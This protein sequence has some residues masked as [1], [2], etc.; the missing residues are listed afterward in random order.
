MNETSEKHISRLQQINPN[1]PINEIVHTF[2]QISLEFDVST[3]IFSSPKYNPSILSKYIEVILPFAL[4]S[5]NR[6]SHIAYTF[7]D[8]FIPVLI[9]YS[10]IDFLKICSEIFKKEKNMSN[11]CPL[12]RYISAAL[13]FQSNEI[14]KKHTEMCL[15]ILTSCTDAERQNLYPVVWQLISKYATLEDTRAVLETLN[16]PELGLAAAHLV[17]AKQKE[18]VPLALK[19]G[20]TGFLIAFL[21]SI[22]GKEP[23]DAVEFINLLHLTTNV[24]LIAAFLSSRIILDDSSIEDTKNLCQKLTN[25]L[26]TA[27]GEKRAN[28]LTALSNAAQKGYIDISL[29]KDELNCLSKS[30]EIRD[31]SYKIII[32]NVFDDYKQS[33]ESIYK[34][35]G[36]TLKRFIE[37]FAPAVP[38]IISK[39]KDWAVQF[40]KKLL[41]VKMQNQV[42]LLRIAFQASKEVLIPEEVNELIKRNLNTKDPLAGKLIFKLIKRYKIRVNVTDLDWFANSRVAFEIIRAP[43]VPFIKELIEYGFITPNSIK[44]VLKAFRLRPRVACRSMFIELLGLA[45]MIVKPLRYQIDSDK[46]IPPIN[47]MD[48]IQINKLFFGT[49]SPFSLSIYG[50]LA[51]ELLRTLLA[52]FPFYKNPNE[53]IAIVIM[54]FCLLFVSS[55]TEISISLAIEVH[56]KV[57]TEATDRLMEQITQEQVPVKYAPFVFRALVESKG[58]EKAC[59]LPQEQ[60]TQA[61]RYDR[62]IASMF[63]KNIETPNETMKTFLSFVGI[64][65]HKEWVDKCQHEIDA[66]EWILADGDKE[67]IESLPKDEVTEPKH[68]FVLSQIEENEEAEHVSEKREFVLKPIEIKE[69]PKSHKFEEAN[70]PNLISFLWF[71]PKKLENEEEVVNFSY[72]CD[73]QRLLL[74]IICYAERFN[75]KLDEEKIANKLNAKN[76]MSII[77]SAL[78]FRSLKY[79]TNEIPQFIKDA[80]ER[81]LTDLNIQ[82]HQIIDKFIRSKPLTKF[83]I[84]SIAALNEEYK[85]MFPKEESG[86]IKLLKSDE[87]HTVQQTCMGLSAFFEATYRPNG[88]VLNRCIPTNYDWPISILS[89]TRESKPFNTMRLSRTMRDTIIKCVSNNTSLAS[90]LQWIDPTEVEVNAA[91]C[92]NAL[93]FLFPSVMFNNVVDFILDDDT[94]KFFS[95]MPPSFTRAFSRSLFVQC[96]P[97]IPQKFLEELKLA[98]T[99]VHGAVLPKGS[100]FIILPSALSLPKDIANAGYSSA[101]PELFKEATSGDCVSYELFSSF[102]DDRICKELK[103]TDASIAKSE[104]AQGLIENS[105]SS[106]IKTKDSVND[107]IKI[108]PIGEV[109]AIV[110]SRRLVNTKN[111]LSVCVAFSILERH[112]KDTEYEEVVKAYREPALSIINDESHRNAFNNITE[113]TVSS[114]L[115]E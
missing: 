90:V 3:L 58:F 60:I 74:G 4:S 93:K 52:L 61:I 73:D 24:P 111:F 6:V 78:F 13:S 70:L 87:K 107:I 27:Q 49:N 48:Q 103:I 63:A 66:S 40:V 17:S 81:C 69:A 104:A 33:F 86:I 79:S 95:V 9:T 45:K 11:M 51:L 65:K 89:F 15:Q 35:G 80:I 101:I 26:T 100:S 77:S 75:I 14:Q 68:A 106:I 83:L 57:K 32:E 91:N 20:D 30:A 34:Q 85:D 44:N 115:H 114:L 31:V 18:L 109:V 16:I 12:L 99:P 96:A 25:D 8:C 67:R 62:E 82:K 64:E 92:K 97:M 55:Y 38:K 37:L 76:E 102:S 43:E 72:T 112:I 22:K 36:Q 71:S 7:F 39:D 10:G 56:R 19:K 113:E 28:I 42:H 94:R 110:C 46:I 105:I 108:I 84:Q 2:N 53:Q 29:V 47:W 23:V 50:A 21:N 88:L 5:D 1:S 41:K 98:L 54:K 59:E